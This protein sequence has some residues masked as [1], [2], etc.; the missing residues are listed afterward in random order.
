MK[1]QTLFALNPLM[2]GKELSSCHRT[3]TEIKVPHTRRA[4]T[5]EWL[6]RK[7]EDLDLRFRY[8]VT[9]SFNKAQTS[10]INQYLTNKKVKNVIFSY[11]YPQR[12]PYKPIRLWIFNERHL[13]GNLH[14]HIL[15][16]GIDPISWILENNRKITIRKRTILDVMCGDY[17]L[18]DIICEGLTNHLQRYLLNLGKGQK[19]T[20]IRKVGDIK[21]RVQYVNKSLDKL[22]FDGWDYI[23]FEHSDLK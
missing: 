18:D 20:D 12:K 8:F 10:T 5:E 22:D 7:I 13:S 16:E 11:F 15:L 3:D 1:K 14:L 9:L 23:D 17:V 4:V 6:M 21:K 19:S 2:G